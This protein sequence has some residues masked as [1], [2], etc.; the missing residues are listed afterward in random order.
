MTRTPAAALH[1][2]TPRA[3]VP[4]AELADL[5]E[6]TARRDV[7]AFTEVYDALAPRV[8]GLIVR[9]INNRALAEEIHQDVFLEV[10]NKA[11]AF[12]R[13]RGSASTWALTIAHRRAIDGVRARHVL[14]ERE[15]RVGVRDLAGPVEDVSESVM[16][17][18]D[19][20][21]LRQALEILPERERL[22]LHLAYSEGRSQSEIAA[23]TGTPLGTVK[24]VTRTALSRLRATLATA[25][26][27]SDAPVRRPAAAAGERRPLPSR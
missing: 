12:D 9:V 21:R 27:C 15:H 10:W 8:F 18:E 6:R 16:H 7:P 1:P 3:Q 25:D 24:T 19:A 11:G 5:I 4:P 14:H 2:G 17:R 13:T 20:R 26:P 23:L 22:F